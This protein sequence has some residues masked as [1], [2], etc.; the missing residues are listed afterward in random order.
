MLFRANTLINLILNQYFNN[1]GCLIILSHDRL[2]YFNYHGKLP[3]VFVNLQDS[4]I[5]ENLIFRYYGCHGIIIVGE[6]PIT[7]FQNVEL[8]M[9][10]A[11]D[12]F[13]FRRY[14]FISTEH[15]CSSNLKNLR[16][17]AMMFVEDILIICSIS[18]R[19]LNSLEEDEYTFELYTHKFVGP[20]KQLTD[21]IWL[22]TWYYR[23]QSFLLNSNLYPDKIC[24]QQGRILRIVCFTYKPF[25]VVGKCL[26]YCQYC[27]IL[28]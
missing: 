21:I 9:K 22:N 3:S 24:D 6:N 14:L 20:R 12:R 5:P 4:N 26:K 19:N 7:I 28:Q 11:Q 13:N 8:K 17:K 10:F 23:N 25:T 27:H 15:H 16:S 18:N 2:D 1:T